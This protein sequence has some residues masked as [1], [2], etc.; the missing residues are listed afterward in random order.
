[1]KSD[2]QKVRSRS[3]FTYLTR[4]CLHLGTGKGWNEEF[5][6]APFRAHEFSFSLRSE[7]VP[8]FRARAIR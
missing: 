8:S 1:V 7:L 2:A 5:C 3:S 6:S 4:H